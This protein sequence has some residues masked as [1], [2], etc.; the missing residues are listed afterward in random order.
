MPISPTNHQS[1]LLNNAPWGMDSK[2]CAWYKPWFH[3]V[4]VI[5]LNT[6]VII[7]PFFTSLPFFLFSVFYL[8]H[9][10]GSGVGRKWSDEFVNDESFTIFQKKLKKSCKKICFHSK[11]HL[12]HKKTKTLLST[13]KPTKFQMLCCWLGSQERFN[14]KWS[15]KFIKLI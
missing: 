10:W 2:T 7:V 6:M 1:A 13:C 3:W 4:L 8:C 11:K 14:I 15:C 12:F 9:V 5:F